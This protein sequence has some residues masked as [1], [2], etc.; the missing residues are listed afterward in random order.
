MNRRMIYNKVAA[1]AQEDVRYYIHGIPSIG[2]IEDMLAYYGLGYVQTDRFHCEKM[3]EQNLKKAG[4][5]Y[6]QRCYR[7]PAEGNR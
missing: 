5:V 1:K 6:L 7:R 4:A 3:H 2:F